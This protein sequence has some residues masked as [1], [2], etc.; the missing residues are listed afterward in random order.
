MFIARDTGAQD[1]FAVT[2]YRS[3][4][5]FRNA[6]NQI[7]GICRTVRG[8]SMSCDPGKVQVVGVSEIKGEKVFVLNFLQGRDSSWVGKPFFAKFDPEAVWF[9]D[10]EPAFG[11]SKFFF[12]DAYFEMHA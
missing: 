12:E 11:D 7:S 3:W 4:Q 6:Y 8:P 10:L 2:L 5:I 9:D 1:Y